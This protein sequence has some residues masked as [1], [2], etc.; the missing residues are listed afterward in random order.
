MPSYRHHGLD[1][2]V[3]AEFT[4]TDEGTAQANAFMEANPDTGLLAVDAGRIIIAALD[5][6]GTKP[7]AIGA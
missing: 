3:V 5:D 1:F 4:D 7:C 2:A 6:Q